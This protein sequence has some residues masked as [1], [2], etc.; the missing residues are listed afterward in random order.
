M[1]KELLYYFLI[2]LLTPLNFITTNFS[3]HG[4]GY[5]DLLS[6]IKKNG[7]QTLY[8]GGIPLLIQ[9]FVLRRFLSATINFVSYNISFQGIDSKFAHYINFKISL[10]IL[11]I[12]TNFIMVLK[13][14]KQTQLL[15]KSYLQIFSNLKLSELFG[16]GLVVQLIKSILELI[17]TRYG[18]IDWIFTNFGYIL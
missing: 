12:V 9:N 18:L 8:Y 14:L 11:K 1:Y 16:K 6:I 3:V 7:L 15:N 2:F 10:T 13:T 4:S 17:I 5:T